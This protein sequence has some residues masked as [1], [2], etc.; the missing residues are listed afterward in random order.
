MINTSRYHTSY[1]FLCLLLCLAFCLTAVACQDQADGKEAVDQ[2]AAD[3]SNSIDESSAPAFSGPTGAEPREDS[4]F[5]QLSLEDQE[6]LLAWMDK[7]KTSYQ[8]LASELADFSDQLPELKAEMQE[9]A[10][11]GETEIF[12]NFKAKCQ[13]ELDKLKAYAGE[14]LPESADKIKEQVDKLNGLY[15]DFLDRL[16]QSDSKAENFSDELQE[17]VNKLISALQDILDAFFDFKS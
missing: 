5:G 6:L 17:D 9:K 16:S 15:Q 7:V 8:V 11:L 10:K 4:D 1:K 12:Q 13:D 3:K 2:P 14:K